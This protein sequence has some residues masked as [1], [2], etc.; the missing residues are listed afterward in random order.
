MSDQKAIDQFYT[1]NG[2][3]CAGCDW[4][5]WINSVLGNCTKSSPVSGD[6]RIGMLGMESCSLK[7]PAGHVLTRRDH[8]CGDFKDE[9]NQE[10][11]EVL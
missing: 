4:W 5:R 10:L 8:V 1:E 2:D 11:K 7:P 3:C 9:T 6:E